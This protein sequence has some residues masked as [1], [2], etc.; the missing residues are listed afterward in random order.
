MVQYKKILITE[1]N[2]E[3]AYQDAEVVTQDL[4]DLQAF[5][6][7]EILYL[8]DLVK[9][10]IFPLSWA[11]TE[12]KKIE[13]MLLKGEDLTIEEVLEYMLEMQSRTYH[14]LHY[15]LIEFKT[16]TKYG[17]SFGVASTL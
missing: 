14:H 2:A 11:G 8:L 16:S 12:S 9:E 13:D 5:L 4:E 1:G 10:D 7:A 15:M 17:E 3:F 6:K